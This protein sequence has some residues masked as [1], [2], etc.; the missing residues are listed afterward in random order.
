MLYT[1]AEAVALE[2]AVA[3]EE[4]EIVEEVVHLPNDDWQP[5][6]QKSSVDPQ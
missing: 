5:A 1:I 2:L 6:P 3:D 4:P